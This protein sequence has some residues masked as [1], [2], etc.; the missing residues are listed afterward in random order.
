MTA[1]ALS[2]FQTPPIAAGVS[3]TLSA[4]GWGFSLNTIA[5][6]SEL[7]LGR[8]RPALSADPLAVF[9]VT[10][11]SAL[12]EA[13]REMRVSQE[14]IPREYDD[15]VTA[16]LEGDADDI[17]RIVESSPELIDSNDENGVPILIVAATLGRPDVVSVL[18]ESGFNPE[19]RQGDGS[20]R[21]EWTALH[22]IADSARADATVALESLRVFIG[23]LS[24]AGKLESFAGWN[25]TAGSDGRPLDVFHEAA[26]A[27]SGSAEK[28]EIHQLFFRHGAE[29]EPPG[30]GRYCDLPREEHSFLEVG[31]TGPVV[32]LSGLG[33]AGESFVLPDGA[34]A[35]ELR[36]LGWVLESEP[37]ASPPHVV[38]VR[39]RGGAEGEAGVTVAATLRTAAGRD[40]RAYSVE[41]SVVE[42]VVDCG[43]FNRR[44]EA[45]VCGDCL[46]GYEDMGEGCVELP[47]RNCPAENRETD[48]SANYLCG[49]CLDE[50]SEI[51]GLCFSN[52]GDYGE[53]PQR[54]VCEAL[55]GL[56]ENG[57]CT[58][59]DV[60]GTFCVLDSVEV[61]PCR[62]LFR[63]VLH[64]Q[65]GV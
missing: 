28:D 57:V 39:E 17:K 46:E 53:L 56:P 6:P 48:E 44:A 60:D 16:A 65:L 24:V 21:T 11:T 58:G 2:D 50:H 33:V 29:C 63:R 13:S 18:I 49:G 15:L 8:T 30:G 26:S 55:R 64:V 7:T 37:G 32:T 4:N 14:E 3:A 5:S 45:N 12:G 40:L 47:V 59:V 31:A 43:V 41:A 20:V 22:Y 23:G 51:G 10:L 19:T 34:R 61:F 9:T 27:G 36:G 54:E 42:F 52:D 1:R 25:L 38:L 35:A 62:G